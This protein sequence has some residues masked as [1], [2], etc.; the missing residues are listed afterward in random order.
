MWSPLCV[1]AVVDERHFNRSKTNPEDVKMDN[2]IPLSGT[3]NGTSNRTTCCCSPALSRR[4]ASA[5]PPSGSTCPNRP[6]RAASRCW[7]PAGRA[8][9]AA[10]HAQAGADRVRRQPARTR[11]Q[12]GGR[13]RAAGALAQHRQAQPSGRCASRC[14]GDFANLALSDMMAAFMQ[15]Y[16]AISLELDLSP[17]RVDLVAEN[18]DIA[19][20]MGDLPDDAARRAPRR[21]FT[22]RPVRVARLHARPRRCHAPRRAGAAARPDDPQPGRRPRA[23]DCSPR[24]RQRSPGPARRRRARSPTR[25]T[26]WRA[27]PSPAPASRPC[28]TSMSRLT[29]RRGELVR[30]L[31]R[32][33]PGSRGRLGGVPGTPADAG[34][35]AR[36][37]R[38]RGGRAQALRRGGACDLAAGVAHA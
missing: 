21:P 22:Q 13:G 12:G 6:C 38:C 17:R 23:V 14:R 28:P 19:I 24:R 25:P 16:P 30:V 4:A 8:A 35:H 31:P 11:A 26:C 32:V 2:I 29:S 1:V 3:I 5:A 27:W 18:F 9:A 15:R 34:A 33:V 10:H 36:L 37:H 7:R 20:R